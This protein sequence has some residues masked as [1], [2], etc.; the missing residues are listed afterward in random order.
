MET[1]TI[2]AP[3]RAPGS[4]GG[5]ADVGLAHGRGAAGAGGAGRAAQSD[6]EAL[7]V[8]RTLDRGEQLVAFAEEV[9]PFGDQAGD[10]VGVLRRSGRLV[11]GSGGR[12]R[13]GSAEQRQV[14]GG[15]D[16]WEGVGAGR[17]AR[18]AEGGCAAVPVAVGGR[19]AQSGDGVPADVDRDLHRYGELVAVAD[20]VVV[21]GAHTDGLAL[22]GGRGARATGVGAAEAGDGDAPDVDGHLDR[23][24]H[25]D[26][27]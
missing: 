12:L 19:V 10:D 8:R 7:D 18:V 11:L 1:P 20:A 6:R 5:G 15:R 26:T 2:P 9:I 4:G 3:S 27:V 14:R 13:D 24:E 25:L 23:R 17:L 16:L 22:R 21:A